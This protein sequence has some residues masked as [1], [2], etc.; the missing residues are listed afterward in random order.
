L[1]QKEELTL[2]RCMI[3]EGVAIGAGRETMRQLE[4]LEQAS[5]DEDFMRR[6]GYRR[7]SLPACQELARTRPWINDST[8]SWFTAY[9]RKSPAQVGKPCASK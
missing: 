6:W 5:T 1:Y 9:S 2:A 4:L 8:Y 7:A 3:G